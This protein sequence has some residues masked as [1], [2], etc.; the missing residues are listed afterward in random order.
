MGVRFLSL[1]WALPGQRGHGSLGEAERSRFLS[2]VRR[3]A[4]F[5]PDL[6]G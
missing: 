1:C 4:F 6:M 3:R 5:R 2:S